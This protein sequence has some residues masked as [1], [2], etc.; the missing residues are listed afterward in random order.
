M[1]IIKALIFFLT[2]ILVGCTSIKGSESSSTNVVIND[3]V[4]TGAGYSEVMSQAKG[5][6]QQYG[7]KPMLNRKLDGSMSP[8]GRSEYNTYYFDCVKDQPYTPTYQPSYTPP[9]PVTS[10][11]GAKDKCAALGFKA[12]TESFGKCVLQLSK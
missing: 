11:E 7:A 4:I 9:P 8:F 10:L 12:G 5:Y 1:Q 2:L 3:H 6:C